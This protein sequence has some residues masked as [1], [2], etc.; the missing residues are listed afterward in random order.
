MTSCLL[1]VTLSLS[2]EVLAQSAAERVATSLTLRQ[3][4]ER[5]GFEDGIRTENAPELDRT[6]T[7]SAFAATADTFV[8]GYYFEDELTRQ[9]T[10]GPMHVSMFNR[11]RRQWS[12]KHDVAAALEQLGLLAGGSVLDITVSPAF[13]LLHTHGNPSAGFCIVLDRSLNVITSIEG[14]GT[15]LT[16]EGG[17]WYF[18]NMIHFAD[19]HQE[20]L[21][22]L[23]IN[24]RTESEIF[25]GTNLS[26]VAMGYRRR[27]RAVYATI[28]ANQHEND[29]D[30]TISSVV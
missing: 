11:T 18:G 20:T 3:A 2:T 1:A 27:I 22:F 6:L 12:H 7:S 14:F 25:P 29:F 28:P 13:V 10:L 23:D 4:L 21:K 19:T 30:R 16:T 26:S 5:S 15:Q 9:A 8:A 24:G 17:L